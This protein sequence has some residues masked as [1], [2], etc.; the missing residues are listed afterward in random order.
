MEQRLLVLLQQS[1]NRIVRTETLVQ[2]LYGNITLDAG[3]VRLKRLVA[4]IRCR[5][6]TDFT[7]RLRTVSR[8]GLILLDDDAVADAT[9]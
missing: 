6:G 1:S 4:D 5:L 2:A 7:C 9:L 8:I 3:R